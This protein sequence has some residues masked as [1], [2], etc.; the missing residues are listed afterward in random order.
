MILFDKKG[1]ENTAETARIAVQRAKQDGLDMVI[2]SI[3]GRTA[4][5]VLEAAKAEGYS[6]R[7]VIV[8]SVSSPKHDG[9]NIMSRE[10]RAELLSRGISQIVTAGHALSGAERGISTRFGGAYPVEIM[11]HTLRCIGA[12]V[13]VCFECSVMALDADAIDYGKPVMAVAGSG[14]GADTAAILTP[15]YSAN[16]LDTIVHEIV[17]KPSLYP[18]AD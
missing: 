11:A 18:A 8:A 17:C 9:K 3:N 16:I 6:G 7:M 13:K 1:I 14:G 12:G 10:K 5:A 15:A 4:E 2:A